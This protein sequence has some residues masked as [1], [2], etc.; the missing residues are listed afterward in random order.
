MEPQR[1]TLIVTGIVLLLILAVIFGTAFF[2]IKSLTQRATSSKPS[3]TPTARTIFPVQ[4]VSS[5]SPFPVQTVAPSNSPKASTKPA[6]S[7]TPKASAKP[8]PQASTQPQP[9]ANSNVTTNGNLKTYTGSGF[10]LKYPANWGLLTCNNS[11][12]FELDPTSSQDQLNVACNFATKPVTILV[13]QNSCSG[14]QIDLGGVKYRKSTNS[15]LVTPSGRG[16][17]YE[18][19][20]VNAPAIDV[21]H[22]V[23][24]GTAFSSQ[25]Y[26]FQIE[27]I[28]ATLKAI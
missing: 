3:P 22:R 7:P 18:W 20:S 4:T 16:T 1:R 5:A 15:Q 24:T 21:T 2:L 13:G 11:S 23:G 28:L 17:G 19:C 26:S 14:N 8:T 9:S 6:A 27:Q 10:E 12:N 25:D